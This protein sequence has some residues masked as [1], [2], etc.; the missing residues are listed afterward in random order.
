MDGEIIVAAHPIIDEGTILGT[1]VLKQNTDRILNLR[2]DALKRIVNFSVISVI[3]FAGI[4]L[5]FSARL[6]RRIRRLGN[7]ATGVIDRHGR[8]TSSRL[9]SETDSGD[10]LGDLARGISNMLTRLHQH[11]QF[12]ENMPRTLRHEINNPLNTLS[13][14]LDNLSTEQTPE[15]RQKY[16]DSARRGLNRI[17][18][19]VQNLADAA[20]LEEALIGE[21]LECLDLKLLLAS[22]VSNCKMMQP[23]RVFTLNVP[24]A[25]LFAWICDY[26]IEQLLDKLIDNAIDFSEVGSTICVDLKAIGPDLHLDITNFGPGIPENLLTSIFDSM[27]TARA[28]NPDNRLHFGIGLYVVRVIADHHQGSVRIENLSEPSGV[29]V[30]VTLPRATQPVTSA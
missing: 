13:T 26:R 28:N 17:G 12:L 24:E 29:R 30:G 27:V 20:N 5:M 4:I 11:N 7:E 9:T 22:Y 18:L 10:E 19:I 1:V 21:D 2:R 16:L 3:I 14:S 23:K 8:L 25:P 15:G 6:A